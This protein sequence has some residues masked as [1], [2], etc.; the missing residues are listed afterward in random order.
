MMARIFDYMNARLA[1]YYALCQQW[2]HERAQ[3]VSDAGAGDVDW[4]ARWYAARV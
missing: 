1:D 3:T 4:F 2:M